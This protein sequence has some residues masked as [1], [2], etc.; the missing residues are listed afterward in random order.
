MDLSEYGV[1]W[2]RSTQ[3][4]TVR[5]LARRIASGPRGPVHE[6]FT[7]PT[8]EPVPTKPVRP[9]TVTAPRRAHSKT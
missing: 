3:C 1:K 4:A 7:T 5:K 9:P 6:A 2:T 8:A